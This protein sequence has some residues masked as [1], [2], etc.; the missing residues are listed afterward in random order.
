M[1]SENTRP[2]RICMLDL[3]AIIPYYAGHLCAALRGRPAAVSLAS[4]TYQH[5]P[6]FYRQA[7]I[8]NRP[9]LVDLTYRLKHAPER[10]RRAS[11]LLEYLVNLAALLL[12]VTVSRP[13]VLHVQF[14]PLS[15]RGLP[16]ERWF[17]DAAKMLGIKVVYTVHNVLPQDTGERYRSTYRRLYHLA[18]RLVCHDV[19]AACRLTAEFGIDPERI[20]VIPHGPLFE[21]AHASPRDVAR[22][23]LGFP[24]DEPLVLWQ[25]I[26]RPYKG[27][28][29]LLRAWKRFC[30]VSAR[31]QLVIAGMGDRALM[32]DIEAGVA[33]LG[34]R[35]RVRLELRFLP[36]RE[37]AGWYDAADI[38]V[39]PYREITTSGALL[40]GMVRGKAILASRLPAFEQILRNGTN[41][42]LIPYGDV[43][44]WAYALF[45]MMGDAELRQSLAASLRSSQTS[46]PRWAEIA[47]RTWDCYRDALREQPAGAQQPVR[48]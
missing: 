1:N 47:G 23:R 27:V 37:V 19:Q 12:G 15:T 40:T 48:I 17:L 18:D 31:G 30:D 35:S 16:L 29:F 25:G 21:D 4:V 8:R 22:A 14:L 32:R 7:G 5:D 41:A 10:I 42:L 44:G 34:I 38:L 36:I 3:A 6:E 9:G 39:Y 33:A 2:L 11:K 45:Q 20:S 43:D 24:R 46:F 26:L 28:E 13:D